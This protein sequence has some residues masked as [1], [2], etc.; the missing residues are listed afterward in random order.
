M[1]TIKN[2]MIKGRVYA[3]DADGN[4]F[5]GKPDCRGTKG[6]VRDEKV[7]NKEKELVSPGKARTFPVISTNQQEGEPK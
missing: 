4:I 6:E 5:K 2:I 7:I 1:M 3:L